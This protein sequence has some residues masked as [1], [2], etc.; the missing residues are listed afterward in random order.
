MVTLGL[1][2]SVDSGGLQVSKMLMYVTTHSVNVSSLGCESSS[3]S[4]PWFSALYLA[5]ITGDTENTL[6]IITEKH[7]YSEI[8][9]HA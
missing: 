7:K 2:F 8:S 5:P 6:A 9:K 3:T 1:L 4:K